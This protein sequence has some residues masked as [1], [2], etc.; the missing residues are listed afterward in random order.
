MEMFV[1]R[2]PDLPL[3]EVDWG[4]CRYQSVPPVDG[5][6][7]CRTGVSVLYSDAGLYVRFD[8]AD[9]RLTCTGTL[10]DGDDLWTE[11]VVELFLWPDE[12]QRVYF[13]YELSPLDRE[14]PLL[15]SNA[16]GGAFMGWSP[17]HYDG[18]RRVW[19]RTAA[20]E[21]GAAWTAEMFIPFALLRGLGNVP[22][23]AGTRWRANFCR[24]DHDGGVPRLFSWAA[25]I[26]DSFHV[27]EK[28]GVLAFE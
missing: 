16:G 7:G 1:P 2:T 19:H 25:G 6:D 27:P 17:W 10:N 15:V 14:L 3:T 11:D 26:V 22:P 23:T 21:D 24:I 8:C 13:E 5:G 18:D 28:F 20:D 12:S 4:E 9:E